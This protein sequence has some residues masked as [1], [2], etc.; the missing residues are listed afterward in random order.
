LV[1]ESPLQELYVEGA[2]V[3]CGYPD[4]LGN[5]LRRARRKLAVLDRKGVAV[6][7]PQKRDASRQCGGFHS[8]DFAYRLKEPLLESGPSLI[9]AIGT[10]HRD[11]RRQDVRGVESW[12]DRNRFREAAAKKSCA[13]Q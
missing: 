4:E 1:E 7:H 8:R 11:V 12:V 9:L 3:V 13:T 6:V 10:R 2:E 5:R